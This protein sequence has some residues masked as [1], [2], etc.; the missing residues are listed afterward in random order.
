MVSPLSAEIVWGESHLRTPSSQFQ[1]DQAFFFFYL[2]AMLY[3][4]LFVADAVKMLQNSIVSQWKLV[5][6]GEANMQGLCNTSLVDNEGYDDPCPVS[7]ANISL[8]C[9][10]VKQP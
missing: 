7:Q 5:T 1:K 9:Q 6:G 2:N 3:R 4:L 8:A 10:L